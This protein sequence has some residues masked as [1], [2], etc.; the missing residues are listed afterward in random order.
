M[1]GVV[2]SALHR[3]VQSPGL[4][5]TR[6]DMPPLTGMGEHEDDNAVVTLPE[7][8]PVCCA[9]PSAHP[10]QARLPERTH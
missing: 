4:G 7:P 6:A 10:N 2:S 5:N 9:W 3:E 8:V 1:A